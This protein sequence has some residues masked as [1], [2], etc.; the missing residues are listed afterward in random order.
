MSK[1]SHTSTPSPT[2]EQAPT[3]SKAVHHFAL[4]KAWARFD[5]KLQVAASAGKI[6][7]AEPL[8]RE[9]NAS[10][11]VFSGLSVLLEIVLNNCILEDQ[12]DPDDSSCNMPLSANSKSA[13]LGLAAEICN[14]RAEEICSLAD[15]TEEQVNATKGSQ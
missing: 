11:R 2:T 15:Q 10:M 6:T 1:S 9:L 12:F 7:N 5:Q 8:V 14:A 4:D 13:L 3:N